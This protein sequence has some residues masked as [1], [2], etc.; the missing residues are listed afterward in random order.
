MIRLDKHY[1]QTRMWNKILYDIL[2]TANIITASF[3]LQAKRQQQ[4]NE[5]SKQNN[6]FSKQINNNNLFAFFLLVFPPDYSLSLL[7]SGVNVK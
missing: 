6:E 5:F 1:K 7:S 2:F 4:N 3:Q